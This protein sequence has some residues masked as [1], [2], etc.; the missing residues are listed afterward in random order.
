[1]KKLIFVLSLCFGMSAHASMECMGV[2]GKGKYVK[3]AIQTAGE[4]AVPTEGMVTVYDQD[5]QYGYRIEKAD[6]SQYYERALF[7]GSTTF[8]G[9]IAYI[10]HENPVDLFY[11]GENYADQDLLA[12][13]LTEGREKVAGNQMVVWKGPNYASTEQYSIDDL[14]C[15]VWA[16]F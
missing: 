10:Q 13:L 6:L 16:D 14:V 1:M 3:V 4:R 11:S 2:V 7:S 5:N 12:V 15:G 8:V 9:T